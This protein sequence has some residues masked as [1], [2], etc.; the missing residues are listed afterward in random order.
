MKDYS[1]WEPIL[2][3]ENLS[4]YLE[5]KNRPWLKHWP[6]RIPKSIRFEPIPVHEYIK[7]T[8]TKFPNNI[9]IH[10]KSQNKKYSYRELVYIAKKIGNSLYQAGVR[11]GDGVGI[12]TSNCPEFI[13]CSLGILQIGAILVPI[14]PLLK[15][16]DVTH[17]IKDAGIINTIFVHKDNFRII[18]RV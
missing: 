10:Y 6:E 1:D 9:C 2:D 11:K 18:K 14:N 17:I 7:R 8:I 5:N 3:Y 13:F 16:A 15:E 4:P 12:M